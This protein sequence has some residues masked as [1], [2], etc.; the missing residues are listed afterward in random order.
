MI[1]ID[2]DISRSPGWAFRAIV[3]VDS[4]SRL[5]GTEPEILVSSRGGGLHLFFP[6]VSLNDEWL[7]WLWDCPGHDALTAY[8]GGC[9]ILFYRRGSM[10][11]REVSDI[12]EAIDLLRQRVKRG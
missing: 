11:S 7:R 3:D 5:F 1:A 6:G 8:R 9:D 4:M 2:Y 12:Y 10:A